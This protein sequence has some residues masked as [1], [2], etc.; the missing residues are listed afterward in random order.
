[1]YS[2]CTEA[3]QKPWVG[4][5]KIIGQ[6]YR[7]NYALYGFN[8][9]LNHNI[10]GH[11]LLLYEIQNWKIIWLFTTSM[12]ER[13]VHLPSCSWVI[14]LASYSMLIPYWE[15]HILF[16]KL[17]IYSVRR[18]NISLYIMITTKSQ[19]IKKES[20]ICHISHGDH[21]WKDFFKISSILERNWISS[22]EFQLP[23]QSL[24]I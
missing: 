18:I 20:N 4:S 3:L 5:N 17:K 9:W 13:I 12:D 15:N 8:C 21:H 6:W 11:Y 14:I 7:R 16:G 1:M 22:T 10:W 19:T 24:D 23:K 2:E